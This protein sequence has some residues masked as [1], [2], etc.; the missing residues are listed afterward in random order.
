MR[1]GQSGIGCGKTG[2]GGVK[3]SHLRWRLPR[4]GE[5]TMAGKTRKNPE[6]L[7]EEAEQPKQQMADDGGLETPA[8][9]GNIE[10]DSSQFGNIEPE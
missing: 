2:A 3:V 8:S 4:A 1:D 10:P 5:M 7:V 9:F 6:P